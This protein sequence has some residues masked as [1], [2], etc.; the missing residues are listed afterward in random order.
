MYHQPAIGA[1]DQVTQK[2]QL[3]VEKMAWFKNPDFWV[4]ARTLGAAAQDVVKMVLG[5]GLRL[6]TVGMVIGLGT[7]LALSRMIAN[8]LWGVSPYDPTHGLIMYRHK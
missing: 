5:Q 8:Q 4:T 3:W 1:D 6:L 2:L 7:S